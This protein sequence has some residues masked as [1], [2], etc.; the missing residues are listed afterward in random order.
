M[1]RQILLY[2]LV[3][4]LLFCSVHAIN[5][6]RIDKKI[7]RNQKKLSY[8][9]QKKILS[10][11][12]TYIGQACN[13]SLYDF[14]LKPTPFLEQQKGV[15]VTLKKN[16]VL[17]GCIGSIVPHKPLYQLLPEMAYNAAFKDSRFAPLDCREL[18]N[19]QFSVS[20]LTEPYAVPDY[21][22]IIIG[23]HGIILSKK[24][25][26]AVFLPEVPI[27]FGWNKEQTL[28]QLSLKAQLPYDAWRDSD[29]QFRV[30]EAINFGEPSRLRK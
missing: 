8:K 2:C 7:E 27:E 22:H 13:K 23:T 19:I 29:T 6:S 28:Q 21:T 24:G 11:I 1:M 4:S 16:G 18:P 26:S 17:R 20:I 3:G 9:E 14:M 30:F 12:R 10:D 25:K 5:K 15:F